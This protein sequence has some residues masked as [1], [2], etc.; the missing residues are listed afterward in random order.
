MFQSDTEIER[1]QCERL[2]VRCPVKFKARSEGKV[3]EGSSKDFSDGGVGIFTRKR[4]KADT[5]LEMQIKL[6]PELK[7]LSIAGKVVWVDKQRPG[8]WRAGVSFDELAF[9]KVMKLLVG[10]KA[11]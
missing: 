2:L 5:R 8:L 10:P 11:T 6:F 3:I 4:L 7:P 9:I 1:R